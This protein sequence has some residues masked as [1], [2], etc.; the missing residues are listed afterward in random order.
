VIVRVW[1][2]RGSADGIDRYCREHFQPVVLPEL[3]ALAGFVDASVLV[4]DGEVVV[5]TRWESLDAVRAF[6]GDDLDRAVVE[7]VVDELLDDYD[8]TVTHYDVAAFHSKSTTSSR[9]PPDES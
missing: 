4:R 7:P 2:G 6:A 1:K 8:A 5:A 3:R 9:R